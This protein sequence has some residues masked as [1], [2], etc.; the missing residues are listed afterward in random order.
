MNAN[1]LSTRS[2]QHRGFTLIELLVVITI[3]GLLI[4]T[5]LYTFGRSMQ[6]VRLQMSV[7][8]VASALRF[9]QGQV[10][11]GQMTATGEIICR[12]YMFEAGG[13]EYW[14]VIAPVL[15]NGTCDLGSNPGSG[16]VTAFSVPYAT[17]V[18]VATEGLVT[19]GTNGLVAN[20]IL[21][22]PPMGR[23]YFVDGNGEVSDATEFSLTFLYALADYPME[24]VLTVNRS[25]Q[26]T[27]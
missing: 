1:M 18:E 9:A 20:T 21:F 27:Y 2:S 22:E 16:P 4:L 26:I 6:Q 12:G 17:G 14:A 3:M 23:V 25:G 7:E 15:S 24:R 11:S 8:Q 5:G 13:E 19:D 10:K